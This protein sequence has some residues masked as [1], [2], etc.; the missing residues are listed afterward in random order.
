MGIFAIRRA[1][2]WKERAGKQFRVLRPSISIAR[3]LH[4]GY[5]DVE[6]PPRQFGDS[7]RA[8]R[9]FWRHSVEPPLRSELN[10]RQVSLLCLADVLLNFGR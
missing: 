3:C 6:W 4:Q 2:D 7:R 9:V 5:F 8:F 1:A 10:L